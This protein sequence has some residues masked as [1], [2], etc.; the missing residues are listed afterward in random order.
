MYFWLS[1]TKRKQVQKFHVPLK[2][3]ELNKQWIRFLN[4]RDW[5][6][7]KHSMLHELYFEDKYSWRCEKCTLELLINPVP[8]VY[9]QKL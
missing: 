3:A 9:P 2:N 1:V 8:T 4:K 5:V 7:V 6:A